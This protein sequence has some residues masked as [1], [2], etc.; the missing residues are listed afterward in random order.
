MDLYGP[1]QI[2][3][4]GGKKYIMVIVNYFSR[5]TWNMFLRTKDETYDILMDFVKMI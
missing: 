2:Q 4:K 1:A 3:I 5:F